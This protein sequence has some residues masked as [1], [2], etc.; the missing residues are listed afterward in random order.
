MAFKS[1]RCIA[2]TYTD[3]HIVDVPS[4]DEMI[5]DWEI[6]TYS[7]LTL[8]MIVG[9]QGSFCQPK[10]CEA[11]RYQ[12]TNGDNGQ[13]HDCKRIF[14]RVWD[15]SRWGSCYQMKRTPKLIKW[16]KKAAFAKPLQFG[17]FPTYRKSLSLIDCECLT[18][19]INLQRPKWSFPLP[20]T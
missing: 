1:L 20:I 2:F 6:L 14:C 15:P 13:P 17:F 4:G 5:K 19:S 8:L 16:G 18:L 11:N 3:V 7:N 12:D 9:I 10:V